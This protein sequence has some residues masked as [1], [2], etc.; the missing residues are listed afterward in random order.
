MHGLAKYY[1]I[2]NDTVATQKSKLDRKNLSL[3]LIGLAKPFS[4]E[5]LIGMIFLVGGS[6]INLLFPEVIRRLLNAENLTYISQ[7]TT[8][9]ILG[10]VLLITLQGFCFYWRSYIF[11]MVGHKAVAKLRKDLFKSL[12]TQDVEFFDTQRAGD[13]VSRLATDTVQV[14]TAVSLNISVLLRYG[15]QVIVGIIL[16]AFMS[17]RLTLVII[18][19]LPI[20]IGISIFLGKKLKAASKAMQAELGKANIVA[21]ETLYGVRTVKAFTQEFF[22]QGRYGSAIDNTLAL[23]RFRTWVAAFFASFTSVLMNGAIVAILAIGISLMNQ[24]NLSIGD[25]TAF[26]LYGILVAISFA[27]LSSTFAEFSQALG[28][29]DRIFEIIDRD[30]KV[31]RIGNQAKTNINN[32]EII[33][34]NISFAYPSRPDH[35]V[36]R[37]IS[38]TALPG[39]SVALVGPSGGGKSTIVSLILRYYDPNSGEIIIDGNKIKDIDPSILRSSMAIVAQDPEIF[40]VTIEEILRYG[41]NEASQSE[42]EQAC[43]DANLLEFIESLPKKF[44]THVGDKGI[45]LSGGQK[46]RLAIARAVLKNPKI[47]ILDEA[48][49]ALDSANESLVQEAIH[50]VM[51]GRTTIAIAHRLSTVKNSD[52]ILVIKD[53]QIVERGNHSELISKNG[54]YFELVTKQ[55]LRP[56]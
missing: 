32:G 43:R 45:Q 38:F 23:A 6:F 11:G 5:I 56:S 49:S 21:E 34:D 13:L 1:K 3:R 36:L 51:K 44:A 22:E 28:A 12:V 53:G 27:F 14:Q 40:S 19:L 10:L 26:L 47:L 46:Q 41:K 15:I 25:L 42:M 18:I 37:S 8:T 29:A 7:N 35:E 4:K 2:M 39:Q 52:Q 55:E 17:V 33:F 31:E 48:T 30:T 16:M 20:L 9:V 54:V 50:R 24:G